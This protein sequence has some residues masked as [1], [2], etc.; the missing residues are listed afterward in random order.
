MIEYVIIVTLAAG[1]LI[2]AGVLVSAERDLKA[3]R[4]HLVEKIDYHRRELSR[5]RDKLNDLNSEIV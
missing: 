5:L 2:T 4:S 3:E 1:V